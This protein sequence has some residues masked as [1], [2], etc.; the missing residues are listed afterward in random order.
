MLLVAGVNGDAHR[1]A[2]GLRGVATAEIRAAWSELFADLVARDLS[3]VW[4]VT[5]DGHA[6][7]REGIAAHLPRPSL[8][9]STRSSVVA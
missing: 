7:L 9:A 6:G 3:G 2:L 1:D 8:L 5:S 4:L